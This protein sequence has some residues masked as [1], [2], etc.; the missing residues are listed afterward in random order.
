MNSAAQAKLLTP[1]EVSE[2]LGVS[3]AWVRDHANGRRRPVLPSVKLGKT[4]RFRAEDVEQFIEA[5]TRFAI[6]KAVA[7]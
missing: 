6:G 5:C 3:E 7:A 2:W 1:R 4:V